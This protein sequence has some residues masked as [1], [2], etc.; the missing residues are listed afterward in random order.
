MRRFSAILRLT[1]IILLAISSGFFGLNLLFSDLGPSETIR[2]RIFTIVIFYFAA[3]LGIGIL[4][5]RRRVLSG[6]AGWGAAILGLTAFM[7]A[8]GK[9]LEDA[10][11]S[12]LVILIVPFT[13]T[14]GW[15][16][17]WLAVTARRLKQ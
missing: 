13:F 3:G 16:G 14:A 1:G 17:A 7:G 4:A 11:M 8:I 9:S 12:I 5:P 15:L 6:V 2:T 10:L